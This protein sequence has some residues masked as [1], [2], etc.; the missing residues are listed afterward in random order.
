MTDEKRPDDER[1][2]S[3]RP[4]IK[5]TDRR[6]MHREDAASAD[7]GAAAPFPEA[8]PP[9]TSD[10][11]A[12]DRV[13]ASLR[14]ELEQARREGR[15]YLDHARRLQ[16]EFD[17][18]RKRVLKEQTRALE[19]AAEPMVRRLLE[20]LDDFE[21]ALMAAEE[22]SA[23]RQPDFE[24]FLKGV[25]LVYAK[26]VD[27]LKA[28]GLER[29]QAENKPFDPEQHEALMQTGEGDGDPVVAD[30]L[31]QGY[32]LNGHVIRPAG[33]RVERR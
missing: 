32:R 7:A 5:V 18:Y 31:R 9:G 15:E 8:G 16:A 3:E 17:N 19:L 22:M 2:E 26:L 13:E 11:D 23:E 24:V 6:V 28:E 30:V 21:L 33:V 27:G 1:A 10:G 14:D 29:I 20:V 12:A 25:E 4:K